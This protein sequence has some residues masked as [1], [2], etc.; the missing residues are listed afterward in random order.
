MPPLADVEAVFWDIGGVILDVDTVQAAH[1]RFV[2]DLVEAYGLATSSEAAVA[3]WRQTVGDYFRERDGTAFRPAREAY[4]RAVE[5]IVGEPLARTEWEPRFRAAV[6][7]A[8]EPVPGA[9]STI[10][11]LAA[12]DDVAHQGVLSDVDADEGRRILERFDVHKHLD[13]VTTSE[14]VGRTKPDP[15][16]FEAALAAA[17]VPPERAV[18]VGDR[19][20]HDMAGAAALGIRTVAHGAAD[21]PAVDHHIETPRGLLSLLGVGDEPA[22]EPSD[23]G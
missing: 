8:I 6:D 1:R 17:S 21:G 20:E 3:T 14:D 12:T 13:A 11:R 4:A 16:M 2:D 22:D 9:T 7:Q 23:A 10:A 19:Y 15:A 5:A 18:M